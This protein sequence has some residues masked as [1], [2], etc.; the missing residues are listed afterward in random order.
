LSTAS[1]LQNQLNQAHHQIETLLTKLV[2]SRNNTKQLK[3]TLAVQKH[4]SAD[5]ISKMQSDSRILVAAAHEA[6]AATQQ[7]LSLEQSSKLSAC[8][9]ENDKLSVENARMKGELDEVKRQLKKEV[10]PAISPSPEMQ[11]LRKELERAEE[12]LQLMQLR[13]K[14]MKKEQEREKQNALNAVPSPQ[15]STSRRRRRLRGSRRRLSNSILQS[16]SSGPTSTRTGRKQKTW[17][18]Q[19]RARAAVSR[20][21]LI[22]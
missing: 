15:S 2:A 13:E 5:A 3:Q 4:Q 18:R 21:S 14:E 16:L 1:S 11:R 19:E 12:Q 17:R 7:K 22:T 8:L 6:A 9:A 10:S 20:T